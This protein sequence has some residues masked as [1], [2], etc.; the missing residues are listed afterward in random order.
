M[1]TKTERCD[2]KFRGDRNKKKKQQAKK[3]GEKRQIN[4]D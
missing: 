1:N 4:N 3:K 2:E